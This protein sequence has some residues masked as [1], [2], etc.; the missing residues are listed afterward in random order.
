MAEDNEERRAQ[1]ANSMY[2]SAIKFVQNHS[3]ADDDLVEQAV[4]LALDEFS[5]YDLYYRGGK[6]VKGLIWTKKP[7]DSYG[8]DPRLLER[9]L[10]DLVSKIAHVTQAE[11]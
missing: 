11:R 5:E 7:L 1:I 8:R 4:D 9:K 6:H 2:F 3:K 10:A